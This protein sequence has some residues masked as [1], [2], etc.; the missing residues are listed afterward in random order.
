MS[1]DGNITLYASCF[2]VMTLHYLGKLNKL[3]LKKRQLWADYILKHQ[4]PKDGYFL[5]P[6][7]VKEE[8]T[9]KEHNW[10][11]VRK[12]LAVHVL[13]ALD[14]LGAQPKYP[15]KFAHDF[16]DMGFLQKWLDQRDW[17]NA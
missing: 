7:I 4:N 17:Q 1:P 9:S 10:D 3:S 15:L 16:L 14:I 5:G 11:V 12:H 8:I 13:P 6:E 2:A